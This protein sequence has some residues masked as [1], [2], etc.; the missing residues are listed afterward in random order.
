MGFKRWAQLALSMLIVIFII[1]TGLQFRKKPIATKSPEAI[2]ICN[3]EIKRVLSGIKQ[4]SNNLSRLAISCSESFP[5]PD[6]K[7]LK[8]E[9]HELI[10]LLDGKDLGLRWQYFSCS[11]L[12]FSKLRQLKKNAGN[13]I[14][15]TILKKNTSGLIAESKSILEPG[16]FIDQ[17]MEDSQYRC[18]TRP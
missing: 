13:L 9:S 3:E 15:L 17:N 8:S 18:C 2:S 16:M 10:N 7:E 5:G 14:F 4:K 12:L 11:P 6:C 1:I